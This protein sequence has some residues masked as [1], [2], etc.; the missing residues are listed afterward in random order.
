M[1]M[2]LYIILGVLLLVATIIAS[3]WFVAGNDSS[4]VKVVR[5]VFVILCI[6]IAIFLAVTGKAIFAILPIALAVLPSILA[7]RNPANQKE[8]VG[9]SNADNIESHSQM[10]KD[11]AYEIL[12]LEYGATKSEIKYAHRELL[13][14]IHPD[15]GGSKYLAA[16]INKAKDILIG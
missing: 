11:E 10:T 8:N 3:R 5:W 15:H 7:S 1:R 4:V 16:Q 2:F 14:K 9:Y 12:G 6:A 13:K